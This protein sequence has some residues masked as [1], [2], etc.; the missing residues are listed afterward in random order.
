MQRGWKNEGV[1]VV[2][3]RLLCVLC[4][5]VVRNA[6]VGHLLPRL[7]TQ[8]PKQKHISESSTSRNKSKSVLDV[9]ARA[10]EDT[11]ASTANRVTVDD[12]ASST[13]LPTS[14]NF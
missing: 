3:A 14:R 10:N 7:S 2:Y 4:G 1:G 6:R 13:R 12:Q 8:R 9:Q 5:V 11:A